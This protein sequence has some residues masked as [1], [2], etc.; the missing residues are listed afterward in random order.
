MPSKHLLTQPT[1]RMN[2]S[3]FLILESAYYK[4]YATGLM[5]KMSGVYSG[6]MAWLAR[7][8]RQLHGPLPRDTVKKTALGPVSFSQEVAEM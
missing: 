1:A 8:N 2:P 3:A 4:R 5:D 6:S 7:G